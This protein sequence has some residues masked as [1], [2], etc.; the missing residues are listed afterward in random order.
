M[1]VRVSQCVPWTDQGQGGLEG[2]TASLFT[3]GQLDLG[4]KATSTSVV[5]MGGG[6][7]V[8]KLPIYPQCQPLS[9]GKHS[10]AHPALTPQCPRAKPCCLS[11]VLSQPHSPAGFPYSFGSP[12]LGT[13]CVPFPRMPFLHRLLCLEN[14]LVDNTC[15]EV[16]SS[17]KPANFLL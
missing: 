3:P 12:G 6:K 14:S 5:R 7:A 1:G 17:L 8:R 2:T 9:H 11:G 16:I 13:D 4:I 15:P 10:R